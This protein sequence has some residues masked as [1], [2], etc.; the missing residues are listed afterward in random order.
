MQTSDSVA[1]SLALHDSAVG[2]LVA[3]AERVPEAQW[4]VP[5]GEGKWSP[6]EVLA[7]LVCTYDT[8][9]RE[10]AG[11]A[12]MA[13]RTRLWQRWLL[14]LTV[15]PGL[16][17]GGAFPKG[18]V[19]PRETRPGGVLDR[20]ESIALFRRRAAELDEAARN[21]KTGQKITHAYFGPATVAR[22]V[23]LCARHI[24]HHAAQLVHQARHEDVRDTTQYQ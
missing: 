11:G 13:I 15:V 17:A 10:L 12:G 6:A 8:L 1:A 21:A 5:M 3:K 20:P 2:D 9:L 22:G 4:F 7:H 24:Q 14:R 16:L 18:A 23:L 19:A